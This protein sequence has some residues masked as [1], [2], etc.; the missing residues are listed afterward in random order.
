MF[1][2]VLVANRGEIALR[3]M[4]T[5]RQMGVA[6][7]AV[8]SDADRDAP[9]VRQAEEAVRIGPA[10]ASESYLHL[11]SIIDAAR[12]TG[13]EAIHPGYGFLSENPALA[14]ACV[15]AGVTFVGP[16]AAAMRL[17]ADKAAARRLAAER[18]I[19]VLPGFATDR[20]DDATLLRRAAEIGFPVMV[21]AVGGGGGRGMRV[22][23]SPDS[24]PEALA[25]ARREAAA[26]FGDDRLLLE[27]A[28]VGGRHIEVQVL[29]DECG[30]TIH[31]G[32]R[33]CSIQRRH[34]KVIEESPAPGVPPDLRERMTAA[35]L[36]VAKAAGYVNA[37]T[38]EFLVDGEGE[39]YFLEM[40]T[41]LQ[42]EH[43]LTEL[44]SGLDLV[45]LQL[46]IAAGEPLPIGQED[47]RLS[48]HAIECRV[49]AEDPARGYL[50]SS[51]RITYFLP[52][53][54][55]GIR[56]DTGIEADTNVPPEYDALL[57][58]LLVHAPTRVEALDRC[59]RALDAYA[60][61]GVKTNLAML[62]SVLANAAFASGTADLTTLEAMPPADFVPRLPDDVLLAAVAVDT[63]GF[64]A[65]G[66]SDAWVALGAWR[67]GGR[68]GLEY[69][70]HGHTLTLQVDRLVGRTN[71]WRTGIDGREHEFAALGG[72]E[73]EVL[74]VEAG[75]ERRWTV[76]RDGTH[77]VLESRGRRYVL[78]RPAGLASG[79]SM[80]AAAA[81]AATL[82][83]PMPGVVVR[84]LVA[85]GAK[86]AAR[87]P[88]VVLEAMK[89]EHIIEA[90]TDGVVKAVACRAGQRVAEGD[91]LI[92][93]ESGEGQ[94]DATP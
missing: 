4:R 44:V 94:T 23:P 18:G 76:A 51:G 21:K 73:G 1:R 89:M 49:Y 2:K 70:Y 16:P 14:E 40:N 45:A 63:G 5:C 82:R 71:V 88:L 52:P 7:V 74:V 78:G 48:G 60:I 6:A 53:E 90:T 61:E 80:A 3:I 50:P 93:L 17:M 55:D 81:G 34:Q 10:P 28:V 35:A 13:A 72:A 19:P 24:L 75:A 42:V 66:A 25:G 22:V 58:K 87:Q 85:E 29:A 69:T 8:Y 26:A 54:G 41:R 39:F 77:L 37:G 84:V 65:V 9:H 33:D 15:A 20:Q 11:P 32:E 36:Q 27:R 57:A 31:L 86:V 64:A 83:A 68:S 43:G 67:L 62:Q 47:V 59:E 91:V 79:V 30:N 12:R 46:R 38:V 56:N 92:E